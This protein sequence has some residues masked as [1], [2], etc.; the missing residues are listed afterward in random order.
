VVRDKK[1]FTGQILSIIFLMMVV[2]LFGYVSYMVFQLDP[3]KWSKFLN[4]KLPASFSNLI[5]LYS[6]LFLFDWSTSG[7]GMKAITKVYSDSSPYEKRTAAYFYIGLLF[8]T[9]Y[10]ICGT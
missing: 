1:K 7:K 10:A 4:S 3:T 2:A 8:A 9:V 5:L 6:C